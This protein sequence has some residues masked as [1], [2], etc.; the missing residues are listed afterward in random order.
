MATNVTSRGFRLTWLAPTTLEANGIV[1]SYTLSVVES[2]SG[3]K[4]IDELEMIATPH[5]MSEEFDVNFLTPY[6]T[7]NC[8]VAAKTVRTGPAAALQVTTAE[9]GEQLCYCFLRGS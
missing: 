9:E 1:R 3:S 7:Y 6:T 4:F 8:S 5:E 2:K